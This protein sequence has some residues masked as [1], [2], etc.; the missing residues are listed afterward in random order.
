MLI[1]S[2]IGLG[3]GYQQIKDFVTMEYTKRLAG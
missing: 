3:W 1:S 2:L